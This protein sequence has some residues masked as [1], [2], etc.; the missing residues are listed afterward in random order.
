MGK[1]SK[2]KAH[3]VAQGHQPGV[4]TNWAD[5]QKQINGY[6]G[7]VNWGCD[8]VEQAEAE[9]QAL[10]AWRCLSPANRAEKL[11]LEKAKEI[12]A[13]M[14]ANS[15][16]FI[17]EYV[18]PKEVKVA[19]NEPVPKFYKLALTCYFGGKN[20]DSTITCSDGKSEIV[21]LSSG[22]TAKLKYLELAYAAIKY[23]DNAIDSGVDSVEIWGVDGSVL[24][25]LNE[26]APKYRERSWVNSYGKPV[27]NREVIE[28]MLELYEKLG[29]KVKL[30]TSEQPVDNDAPF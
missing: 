12:V 27:A 5:V 13:G 3:V 17:V 28:P 9:Y 24:V 29:E 22:A 15:E 25:T 1:K 14:Q 18:E 16:E 21:V 2:A 23:A 11:T 7:K 10:C 6:K 19:V 20:A 30:N 8:S 4:Y 26:W